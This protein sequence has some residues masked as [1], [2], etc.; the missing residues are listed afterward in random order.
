DLVPLGL[1]L[2]APGAFGYP[3]A[4][5]GARLK[6][7]PVE[8]FYVMAGVYNGDPSLKSG[9]QH[10]VDFSLHGP[11]FAI[12]EIGLRRNYGAQ[13]TGLAGNLKL[14]AY[15]DGGRYGV[16]VVGDQELLRLGQPADH[17]HLGAFGGFVFT[18]ER[19]RNPVPV[20]LDAGL[21]L[22]GP[23]PARP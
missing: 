10:G 6:V 2:N 4:T 7:E 20:F 1:F 18:P 14:G 23:V 19:K 11:P 15:E 12:G 13:A 22:Y 17:R 8:R 16:Y 9:E 21:V 5:W 3:D